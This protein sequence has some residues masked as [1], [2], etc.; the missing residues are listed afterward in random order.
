MSTNADKKNVLKHLG[1]FL[2]ITLPV[3]WMLMG[4]A[5]YLG[6]GNPQGTPAAYL[7]YMIACFMPAIAGVVLCV[8]T[9]ESVRKLKFLPRLQRNGKTYALAIICAV[10][11]SVIDPLVILWFFPKV[12]S[13]HPEV[14]VIVIVFMVLQCVAIGCV[15]F[16]VLMGEEIGWMGY[17]FPRLEKLCG[18]TLGIVM[19]GVVRGLWH[20][21]LFVQDG[22]FLW[23]DFGILI[24]TNIVGGCFLVLL[25]KMSESVVPAAIFHGL[26]NT[27]PSVIYSYIVMDMTAYEKQEMMI[28]VVSYI[29]YVLI[30]AACYIVIIKKFRIKE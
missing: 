7:L 30:M 1:L 25:T 15:Q 20:I 28:T 24:F 9:K 26:T 23:K 18:T 22:T 16:F 13:L 12:G 19:T 29:P 14:P 6:Y 3:T 27:I 4:L 21:V 5:I 10:V 2:V 11:V 17:L 8:C